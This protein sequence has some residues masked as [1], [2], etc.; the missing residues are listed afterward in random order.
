[1]LQAVE[2]KIALGIHDVIANGVTQFTTSLCNDLC[3]L[4][5]F[6][7]YYF[8]QTLWR[9]LIIVYTFNVFSLLLPL[10]CYTVQC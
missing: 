8:L 4:S 7:L 6:V 9:V 10:A 1:M 2:V 3:Q 5:M